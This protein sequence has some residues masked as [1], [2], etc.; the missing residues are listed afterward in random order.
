VAKIVKAKAP[1]LAQQPGR[2]RQLAALRVALA[3]RHAVARGEHPLVPGFERRAR[4][5]VFEQLH[6]LGR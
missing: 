1:A 5:V 2:V 4:S 3:E 6:E